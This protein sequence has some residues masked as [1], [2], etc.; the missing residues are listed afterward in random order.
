[1]LFRIDF[2]MRALT[3]MT[4]TCGVLWNERVREKTGIVQYAGKIASSFPSYILFV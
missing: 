2:I 1:M 4:L 3:D